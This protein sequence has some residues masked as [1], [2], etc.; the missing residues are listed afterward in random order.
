MCD[1]D[2]LVTIKSVS[3]LAVRLKH[4][5]CD[6][7]LFM[8]WLA[9]LLVRT[10]ELQSSMDPHD[11]TLLQARYSLGKCLNHISRACT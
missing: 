8:M 4:C 5:P 1:P 10:R 7:P 11:S 3:K 6:D 2:K 9:E